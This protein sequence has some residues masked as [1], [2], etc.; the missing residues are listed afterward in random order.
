MQ[1]L[2]VA[3]PD[4]AI[5]SLKPENQ[6]E[7]IRQRYEIE[8]I[9]KISKDRFRWTLLYKPPHYDIKGTITASSAQHTRVAGFAVH[10]SQKVFMSKA[11][12]GRWSRCGK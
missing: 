6:P 4:V 3:D 10:T 11:S 12:G 8:L 9:P 2:H 7:N 5:S 1:M